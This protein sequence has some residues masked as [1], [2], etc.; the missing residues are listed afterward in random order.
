MKKLPAI[1]LMLI[2]SFVSLAQGELT[3]NINYFLDEESFAAKIKSNGWGVNYRKALWVN[4]YYKNIY[5]FEFTKIRDEKEIKFY[6]P[7][8][9]AAG[10]IYYGKINDAFDLRAGIG[11]QKVITEKGDRKSV[12]IRAFAT[13]GASLA[14]MKPVY[15]EVYTSNYTYFTKFDP[16][17]QM[18]DIESMA[19]Y[20]KGMEEIKVSPGG[21]LK[22]GISFEHSAKKQNLAALEVGACFS[23]YMLP[24]EIIYD[25]KPKNL[26]LN[27][28][29]EYRLGKY[30]KPTSSKRIRKLS[31]QMSKKL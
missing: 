22:I 10:K 1:L 16:T 20:S 19:P 27:L 24:L 28:F 8:Y 25:S 31:E 3:D 23:A 21:Y 18:S 26:F 6:N 4:R 2:A 13:A 30:I 15:Y 29:L 5:E 17:I 11:R 9:I 7:F 12:E 14:F